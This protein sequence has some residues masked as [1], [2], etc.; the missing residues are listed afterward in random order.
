MTKT[1][2]LMVLLTFLLV[3]TACGDDDTPAA[4]TVTTEATTETTTNT[5]QD[6][7][8]VEWQIL[9]SA[10]V[11][12]TSGEVFDPATIAPPE[13]TYAMMERQDLNAKERATPF[14]YMTFDGSTPNP[15]NGIRFTPDSFF[16]GAFIEGTRVMCTADCE[17]RLDWWLRPP[18][19]VVAA[20]NLVVT[21]NTPT[22]LPNPPEEFDWCEATSHTYSASPFASGENV[23]LPGFSGGDVLMPNFSTTMRASRY[24][25]DGGDWRAASQYTFS[26]DQSV[27]RSTDAVSSYGAYGGRNDDGSGDHTAPFVW[28]DAD[29]CRTLLLFLPQLVSEQARVYVTYFSL[30]G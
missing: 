19:T 7:S 11:T 6:W 23:A 18:G 1:K 10:Y 22:M 5:G 4:T 26:T 25:P 8:T 2:R 12:L 13:A 14:A 24:E 28:M 16:A 29:G 3:A 21:G 20:T 15:N 9:G 27:A 17:F 30:V